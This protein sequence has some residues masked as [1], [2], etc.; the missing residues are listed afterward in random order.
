MLTLDSALM[1]GEPEGII[2]HHDRIKCA[3]SV[4]MAGSISIAAV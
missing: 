4:V 3:R 1:M 2:E